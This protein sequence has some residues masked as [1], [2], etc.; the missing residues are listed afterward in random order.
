MGSS[1]ETS[2]AVA[3]EAGTPAVVL[4]AAPVEGE[5]PAA[6]AHLN[7]VSGDQA[8]HSEGVSPMTPKNDE[9]DEEAAERAAKR[10][11]LELEEEK[12][13][14]GTDSKSVRTCLEHCQAALEYVA[15]QQKSIQE[16]QAQLLEIGSLAHH[17]ES[18]QKYSLA[19]VNK[20]AENL[21]NGMWQL[22]GNKH[23][24][25]TT[26]KNM[27]QQLVTASNKGHAAFTKLAESI[28]APAPSAPAPIPSFPPV[29]LITPTVAAPVAESPLTGYGSAPTAVAA[30]SVPAP[31]VPPP[32]PARPRAT[33]QLSLRMND[34]TVQQRAASPT[35]YQGDHL[36]SN[37]GY[38]LCGD[39]VYRRLL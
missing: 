36:R 1:V 35:P 5:M 17:S 28:G 23:E 14:T 9:L 26:L 2:P 19:V 3:V 33:V 20:A 27:M 12:A 39:G 24:E 8:K 29:A 6:E 21:R 38:A 15:R 13:D 18:C 16:L 10:A 4:G 34:G 32:M 37:P 11:K 25:K 22:T 30:G 7:E 31:P